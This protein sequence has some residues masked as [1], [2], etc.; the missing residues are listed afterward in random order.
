MKDLLFQGRRHGPL[1]RDF[2]VMERNMKWEIDN[3]IKIT[4]LEIGGD[5]DVGLILLPLDIS[6]QVLKKCQNELPSTTQWFKVQPMKIPSTSSVTC[7]ANNGLE[8]P[9]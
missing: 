4:T 8:V 9:W 1:I 6:D 3:T 5:I 2:I 7:T